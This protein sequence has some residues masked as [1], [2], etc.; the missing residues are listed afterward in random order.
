M[1]SVLTM[2]NTGG[3]LAPSTPLSSIIKVSSSEQTSKAIIVGMNS[4]PILK[5]LPENIWR[6]KYAKLDKLLPSNLV[7]LELT[8][9]DLK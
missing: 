2:S 8:L 5:K 7:A 3:I 4:P 9:V 6:E 1:S